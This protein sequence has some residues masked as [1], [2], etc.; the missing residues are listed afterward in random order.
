MEGKLG[1]ADAY[2]VKAGEH[3]LFGLENFVPSWKE[4]PRLALIAIAYFGACKIALLFPDLENIV[5]TIW[6]AAGIGLAALLLNPRRLWPAILI[7]IFFAGHT[8]NLVSGRPL[9]NSIGFMT[10]NALESLSCA[11]M[12]TR[13]CGENVKFIKVQEIIALILAATIVNACTAF[14]A[15]GNVV[16]I[17]LPSFWEFW[18][19]WWI[20]DGLG[21][22]LVTPLIVTWGELRAGGMNLWKSHISERVGFFIAWCVLSWWTFS[23]YDAHNVLQLQP[24]ML[25]VLLAW[26]TFRMGRRMVLLALCALAAI[27]VISPAVQNGPLILGGASGS[28]RLLHI[29]MFIAYSSMSSLLLVSTVTEGR[30]ANLELHRERMRLA[31]IIEG[32]NSGT[33]EWNIQTGQFLINERWAQ[34]VGYSIEELSPVS[35]LTWKS[36][37]HPEDLEQSGKLLNE[38][39]IGNIEC[40]DFECR[41]KHKDGHWVWV[42]DRGKVVTHTK[43]GM[44][45]LM[46]GAH[47]EIT[48]RKLAQELREHI[49]RVVQHDLRGP[50]NSAIQ[51]SRMLR[52]EVLTEKDRLLCFDNLERTGESMLNTL[53]SSMDIFKIET[54]QYILKPK[55]LD[56]LALLRNIIETLTKKIQ[57]AHINLDVLVSGQP[58]RPDTRCLCL[59][60]AHLLRTA[61][62]NLLVNALEASIPSGAV[63]VELSSSDHDC[64]IKITNHGVVPVEIRDK[65]F[66]RYVTSG[67][68]HGTGIG[69][70]SA[71]MMVKAMGGDI[72]MNTSDVDN[73]TTV[74]VRMPC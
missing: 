17:G 19:T 58:P 25:I 21:I 12:M 56:F 50:A 47:Q 34:I 39:F 41:M 22:L 68:F 57:F 9:L 33:W 53:N 28:E 14:I 38:H 48:E 74:T 11:W 44:P 16:F 52:D 30:S 67:K 18:R 55:P 65:F 26:P 1:E 3:K 72:T 45:L 71:R 49:E 20:A 42:H 63:A 54:G 40:Y 6:P 10:V 46:C 73:E 69:T 62:H 7:T 60:D 70:Y 27:A 5:A 4:V 24:Y 43:D 23:N 32:T 2:T 35:I 31:Y 8:A 59:G 51:L 61:L 64:T 37:A 36:L 66:D 29:Q 15:A 13:L